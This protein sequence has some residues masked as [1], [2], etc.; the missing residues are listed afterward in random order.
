MSLKPSGGVEGSEARGSLPSGL[1]CQT[2]PKKKLVLTL[3]L[4][5]V[6]A[7]S[8]VKIPERRN[9]GFTIKPLP[10]TLTLPSTFDLMVYI[11]NSLSSILSTLETAASS[12]ETEQDVEA[13]SRDVP[14]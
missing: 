8:N 6:T 2:G 3:P 7:S 1:F 5:P 4:S 9:R 13:V 12:E 10:P 14:M 11:G